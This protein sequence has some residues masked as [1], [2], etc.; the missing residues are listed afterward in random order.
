[1]AWRREIRIALEAELPPVPRERAAIR[2]DC[3]QSS[4]SRVGGKGVS[5]EGEQ[6][7]TVAVEAT[8]PLNPNDV[9]PS[10]R[11]PVPMIVP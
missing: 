7:Y 2:S 5:R 3:W 10:Y 11:T 8:S 1:M 4:N 9:P 6:V